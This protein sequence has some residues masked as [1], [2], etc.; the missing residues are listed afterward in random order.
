MKRK[1]IALSLVVLAFAMAGCREST[2]RSEGTVLLSVADFDALPVQV[3][4]TQGPFDIDGLVLRNIPKDPNGTTSD[5]QSIELRSYEVRYTRRDT[6]TRIP[7]S[8]VQGIFSVVPVGGQITIDNLPIM[9]TNQLR[10]PPLSDLADLGAD[11]E[12]GTAVVVLNG[13][14]RF[15]GRTLAG[16]DIVS[17]PANFTIEVV[18]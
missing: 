7:P 3:S 17:A 11:R 8:L 10:T 15:F 2:D 1:A 5:L 14:I 18:P 16:D 12:T 13:S 9:L 4:V 6:G